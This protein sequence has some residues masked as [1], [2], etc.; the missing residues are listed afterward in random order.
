M[1]DILE[2]RGVTRRFAGL[3]AVNQVSFTLAEGEILGLIGPN[4]AGKTTLVSLISGTLAPTHGDILYQG[5]PIGHLPAYRRAR[6]GIGRTFQIMRPFPGLSV[7]DNVAV[8]ALFGRGGGQPELAKAR[9]QARACLDFVGLGRAADQRAEE[10]GGPGR[11]RLELAKA[12]AMQPR[13]LLCDEVMA[14]LNL[15]E[16]E[17]VIEVIRKVRASGISV[18]VIEH[19]IKAIKTLSDRLLVLHHGEKIADGAPAEV[20]ADAEV[21]QAY[22][23]RQRS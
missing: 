19:V 8:G 3:V 6:L 9:E 13:I 17:E 4:G 2:I 7:L 5:R 11:K 14:G 20:L 16:I 23:G 22:L 1:T 10:L 21:V 15:V 18:L 12:L